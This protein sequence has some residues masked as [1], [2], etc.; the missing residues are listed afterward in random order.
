MPTASSST[1]ASKQKLR[2][3]KPYDRDRTLSSSYTSLK[4][5]TSLETGA[6]AT[7]GQK[8]RKGKKAWRKNIDVRGEE[9]AL[10]Q[11]REEER[12]TGY[13]LVCSVK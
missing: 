7:H 4:P 2:D 6:P 13:V 10:E 12:V 9:E 5:T 11:A 1:S 3:T 8:T